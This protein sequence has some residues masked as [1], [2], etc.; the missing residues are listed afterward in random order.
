MGGE[1]IYSKNLL[2]FFLKKQLLSGYWSL[3]LH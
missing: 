2:T 1:R 3:R